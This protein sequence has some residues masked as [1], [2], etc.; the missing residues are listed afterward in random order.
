MGA[1][2]TISFPAILGTLVRAYILV[3]STS[4]GVHLVVLEDFVVIDF[5]LSTSEEDNAIITCGNS[6][7]ILHVV[8]DI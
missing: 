1:E 3:S 4:G 8:D 2:C 5:V 6:L 7:V